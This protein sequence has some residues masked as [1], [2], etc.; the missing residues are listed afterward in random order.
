MDLDRALAGLRFPDPAG[1][2]ELAGYSREAIYRDCCGGGALYL[3]ARMVRT[4]ALRPG[5]IVLDLG[6][7]KG[8][9]SIFLAHH[10]DVQVIAVDL[11][12]PASYL[13][14]KL[15][16]RGYRER[17][18]PLNLDITGRLPFAGEYFDAIFC[19]NSFSFYGGSIDFLDHLLPHLKSGG[20][21]CIGSEVLSDEFTAEQ[22]QNPPDVYSFRLPP[23]NEAVDV[24]EDDFKK[25]HTPAWWKELFE[26]SG[27]LEVERCH[28]L[29]DAD[30]LYEDLVRYEHDYGVGPFDVQICL[31]QIEWGEQ[32]RPR[33]SLFTL[34]ARKR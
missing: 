12:T 24:F 32:N 13:H 30:V 33:K 16:A 1:Y 25:Q 3:A 7:G 20:Q 10:F 27:R 26:R 14:E 29:E 17:I 22:L 18:V 21:I 28:E 9:T 34:T 23:P 6:C 5:D 4:M 19:M 15:V 11:W 8:E 2:P 31:R